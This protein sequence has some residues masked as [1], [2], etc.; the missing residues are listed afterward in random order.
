M[1]KITLLLFL[2][3]SGFYFAQTSLNGTWYLQKMK[4]NGVDH[5]PQTTESIAEVIY[6]T[7]WGDV[8]T[9]VCLQ[10][11]FNM[12]NVTSTSYT[13]NQYSGIYGACSTDSVTDFQTLYLA[14]F[15]KTVNYVHNYVI[16]GSGNSRILT[17]TTGAG[18]VFVYGLQKN[19]AT[20]ESSKSKSAVYPN[21]VND[22]LYF[23]DSG[24]LDSVTV[25]DGSGKLIMEQKNVTGKINVSSLHKGMYLIVSDKNGELQKFNV[26]KK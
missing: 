7:A 25:Y 20:T 11:A 18:D 10:R 8:I 3:L 9:K 4:I 12:T 1:K 13:I 21:P 5:F 19:L 15:Q 22:I 24:N 14:A 2:L 26:I 23:K 16:T 17:V 6:D